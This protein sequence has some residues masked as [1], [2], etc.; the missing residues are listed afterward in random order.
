MTIDHSYDGRVVAVWHLDMGV[1]VGVGVA[2][3]LDVFQKLG[4]W[5]GVLGVVKVVS[6]SKERLSPT[7]CH[8]R[9]Y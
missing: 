9:E 8:L 2:V 3:Y 6:K 5:F 1:D 7:L 4:D